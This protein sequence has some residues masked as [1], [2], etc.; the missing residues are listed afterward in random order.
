MKLNYRIIKNGQTYS[1]RKVALADSGHVNFVSDENLSPTF[2]SV[3]ELVE[4]A[5]G[6]IDSEAY[7]AIDLHQ[8]MPVQLQMPQSFSEPRGK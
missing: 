4:W 3:A 5:D 1:V 6:V 8:L 2:P 7:P